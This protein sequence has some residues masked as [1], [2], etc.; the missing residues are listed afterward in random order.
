MIERLKNGGKRGEVS[1]YCSLSCNACGSG[2]NMPNG[3][4]CYA[5]DDCFSGSCVSCPDHEHQIRKCGKQFGTP[6][7]SDDQCCGGQL[8]VCGA[9]TGLCEKVHESYRT[10]QQDDSCSSQGFDEISP[11]ECGSAIRSLGFW[12]NDQFFPDRWDKSYKAPTDFQAC[13]FGSTNGIRICKACKYNRDCNGS[14]V[15]RKGKCTGDKN[16]P[17]PSPYL[18]QK[19]AKDRGEKCCREKGVPYL[20]FGYCDRD[21]SIEQ[22]QGMK[23][24]VCENWI[25]QIVKCREEEKS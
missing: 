21:S 13:F 24:G 4:Q 18:F 23:T 9:H 25:Q 8:A 12:D 5:S 6:C 20:C 3:G 7:T 17:T 1:Q 19:W 14:L 11:D 10:V 15:C 22:R 16:V 2:N